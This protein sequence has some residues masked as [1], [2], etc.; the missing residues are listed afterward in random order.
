MP[1]ANVFLIS[2]II[3]TMNTNKGF[4]S[5]LACGLILAFFGLLV[6]NLS[7]YIGN[8]TQVGGRMLLA[9]IFV[10]PILFYKK[11]PVKIKV[12][13]PF[14]F[15]ALIISFPLYIVFFT[16]SINNTKIANAF[17]YLFSCTMLTSYLLGYFIFKE[18]IN[19]QKIIVATLSITGLIL[20][21]IPSS[22][23][24]IAGPIFGIIGGVLYGISNATRK[25]YDRKINR[26]L[27][28]FLQMFVGAA[29]SFP[30]AYLLKELNQNQWVFNSIFQLL[31]FGIVLVLIQVLLFNGFSNFK[32]NLGSIVLASQLVFVELI[33][34]FILH[35]IPTTIEIVGSIVIS[36]S[37]I[38]SNININNILNK[39]YN[40]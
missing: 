10:I 19:L 8:F 4:F 39:G 26:W 38:L 21:M 12:E 37:V 33:G 13:N 27:I 23:N 31:L 32:L 28:I 35:E 36:I 34:I 18:K 6:R 40:D 16:L 14:L 17:F 25:F 22:G 9:G 1:S 20:F 2:D 29:V 30:I 11:I 5:L 7:H 24:G 15:T 3:F